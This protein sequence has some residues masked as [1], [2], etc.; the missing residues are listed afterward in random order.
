[1]PQLAPYIEHSYKLN[2]SYKNGFKRNQKTP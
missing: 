2:K 1:M